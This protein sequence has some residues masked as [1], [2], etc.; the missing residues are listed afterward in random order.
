LAKQ[1]PFTDPIRP[2]IAPKVKE[3]FESGAN[4]RS[5]LKNVK[6]NPTHL[7]ETENL[8]TLSERARTEKSAAVPPSVAW[9]MKPTESEDRRN[10]QR[11]KE[12]TKKKARPGTA[13]ETEQ[14]YLLLMTS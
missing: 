12:A 5:K 10:L 1:I 14:P 9:R 6:P 8:K 4:K 7:E 11:P 3:D 13:G 2:T